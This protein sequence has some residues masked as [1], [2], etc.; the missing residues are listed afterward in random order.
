M[1]TTTRYQGIK[2]ERDRAY[3]GIQGLHDLRQLLVHIAVLC[4]QNKYML[5][6]NLLVSACNTFMKLLYEVFGKSK[7]LPKLY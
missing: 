2:I 3:E 1:S 6:K 7:S 5:L 4:T